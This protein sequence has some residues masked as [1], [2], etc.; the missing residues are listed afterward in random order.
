SDNPNNRDYEIQLP[1]VILLEAQRGG[2]G[3]WDFAAVF[4]GGRW[5]PNQ[6]DHAEVYMSEKDVCCARRLGGSRQE[7]VEEMRSV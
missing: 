2:V 5:I 3:S 6:K 7:A 1:V 4:G